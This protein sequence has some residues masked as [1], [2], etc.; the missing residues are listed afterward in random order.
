LKKFLILMLLAIVVVAASFSTVGAAKDSIMIYTSV[1][2]EIMT[3]IQKAFETANPDVKLEIF[4]SG[5]SKIAAKLAAEKE[6]NNIQADVLW[7]AEFSYYEALK[8]Q[9]ILAK[10]KP[11]GAEKLAASLKDKDGYY[12]AGRL[13][14]MVIGYNTKSVTPQ[15][16]PATWKELTAKK[17]YK[18]VVLPSPLYSGSSVCFVGAL[19]KKYGWNYFTN[20]R[21]NEAVVVE[22]NGDVVQR[23]ASGEFKVGL[24]LDYMIIDLKAKGSP[25]EIVYPKDGIVAVPSPIGIVKTTKKMEASQKFVEYILSQKGQ[26]AMVKLG[27]FIPIR[28]DVAPPAGAPTAQEVSKHAMKVDWKYI[29]EKT[30]EINNK[31]SDIMLF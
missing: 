2:T 11:A 24:T 10:F 28:P 20:L 19:A 16:A 14:N 5:T 29:E 6:A 18:S 13:I 31:F 30:E 1:P 17:W 8:K 22:A 27:S 21:G 7:L 12:Y 4:R 26:E 9:G 23:V 3:D 15:E 25:I